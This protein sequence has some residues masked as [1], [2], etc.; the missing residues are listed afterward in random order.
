MKMDKK[1]Q[2]LLRKYYTNWKFKDIIPS[3]SDLAYGMSHGIFKNIEIT[4]HDKIINEIKQ[5]SYELNVEEAAKGFLY[6]LSSGDLRY[7]TAISSLLWARS[8]PEHEV[9]F[10]YQRSIVKSDIGCTVCNMSCGS[11]KTVLLSSDIYKAYKMCPGA[12]Y[13]SDFGC[14]EYVLLDLREFYELDYVEPTEEDYYIFNRILGVIKKASPQSKASAIIK[15]IKRENILDASTNEIHALLGVLSMCSIMETESEYGYLYE[16]TDCSQ[17]GFIYEKDFYYPLVHW[18]GKDGIN[19]EAIDEIFGSF[20]DGKFYPENSIEYDKKAD[21]ALEDY[22]KKQ[23]KSSDGS[24]F[25]EGVY[26]LTL[27]NIE[28]KYLAL[29]EIKD[30]YDIDVF[31]STKGQFHRRMKLF[32]D[33]NI[34]LKVIIEEIYMEENIP[35]S[36]FYKEFDTHL[37]TD[38][39]KLILPLTLK[40][41]PKTITLSNIESIMPFG[42]LFTFYTNQIKSETFLYNL[43]KRLSLELKSNNFNISCDKDFH[44]YMDWYISSRPENYFE[45]IQH[46]KNSNKDI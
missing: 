19:Y 40:G 7:R 18:H 9:S 42:C 10:L 24:F 21:K 29:E 27:T 30:G 43:R 35:V 32:Y 34:I 15:M 45:K 16:F 13:C 5:L 11:G 41:R 1:T 26:I 37:E 23:N 20:S 2:K 12:G 4:T 28:R 8:L 31:F 44:K 22:L 33:K 14:A 17:R 38:E 39:R 36:Q 46:F 3:E 6:S 25:K